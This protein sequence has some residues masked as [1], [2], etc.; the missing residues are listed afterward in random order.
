MRARGVADQP[1]TLPVEIELGGRGA[2]ELHRGLGV[3]DGAGPSIHR[4]LHQPVLDRKDGI[5]VCG[6]VVS[7]MVIEF[8]VAELPPAPMDANQPR[9][10]PPSM[11]RALPPWS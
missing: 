6:E 10:S 3:V 11:R 7:P 9:P 4:R 5:A 2:D 1:D 8:A